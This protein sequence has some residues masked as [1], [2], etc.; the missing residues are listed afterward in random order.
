[1][2]CLTIIAI[3]AVVASTVTTRAT[4]NPFEK[5]TEMRCTCYMDSGA[6]A[7]GKQTRPFVCAAKKEWIGCVACLYDVN[8]DG[9]IGD[10]IGYY[11]ILDTGAGIDTDGDGIGDSIRNGQSIDIWQPDKESCNAWIKAHGDYVFVYIVEGVG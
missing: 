10:F 11:E 4:G 2:I 8:E 5:P 7:S 9:S 3:A 1:M 6:M